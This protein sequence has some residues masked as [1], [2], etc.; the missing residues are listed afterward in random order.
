MVWTYNSKYADGAVSYGGYAQNVRVDERF[1]FA[2]P[3]NLP[4]HSVAPLLC[5][6]ATVF[7]PLK[8]WKVGKGTKLG[9]LGIGG[10][11]HLGVKFGAALGAEVTAISHSKNKGED[12]KA[13]GA[14]S[15]LC[16]SDNEAMKAAEGTLDVILST[17]SAN[18]DWSSY[19]SLLKPDGLLIMVGLPEEKLTIP[20][21]A[22]IGHRIS[23]AGSLIGSPKDIQEMLVLASEKNIVADTQVFP[24]EKVNEAIAAFREG[25]PK[26]RFVLEINQQSNL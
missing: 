13:L 7:S 14:H 21:F 8:H 23:I 17:V 11:G 16:S 5:A 18:V 15:F 4:S 9:V 10:L 6:G 24:I 3:E 19:T 1:A 26:Y 20:A 25:K 22:L 12:A 2:I